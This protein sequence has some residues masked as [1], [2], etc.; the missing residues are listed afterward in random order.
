MNQN[1]QEANIYKAGYVALVGKPNVG[2]STLMNALVGQ[3]LSIATHKPQTT[4]HRILG[5][6]SKNNYQAIFLDTPG[7]ID[8][9]YALQQVMVEKIHRAI[10]D[11]DVVL[12]ILDI[13][14]PGIP[15][16][17]IRSIDSRSIPVFLILNKC[18]L[19]NR[20]DALPVIE[21]LNRT[22][23]CTGII[24]ISALRGEGIDTLEDQ[25]A[26]H[27]PVHPPYYPPDIVTEHPERFFV[28]EIIREQIFL[29]YDEEIPYSTTVLIEDFTEQEGRKDVIRAEI[30]VDRESQKPII[31][32]KG[33]A[34]LKSLGVR[35]RKQIEEFLGRPVFLQLFVKTR[36]KWRNTD[37]W[38][39]RFGYS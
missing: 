35:A 8:P 21:K 16:A 13:T 27:L 23:S 12:V 32:G 26:T 28:A 10:S 33:G 7:L 22:Y 9:R 37:A 31:I 24:P 15:D 1:G 29:L 19:I 30:V 39:K 34:K 4:R 20:N 38:L 17:I 14:E 11:A 18:D 6:L 2:K 3:K 25:I 36:E 5:I